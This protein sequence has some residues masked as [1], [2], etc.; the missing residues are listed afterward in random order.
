MSEY[1]LPLFVSNRYDHPRDTSRAF[2]TKYDNFFLSRLRFFLAPLSLAVTDLFQAQRPCAGQRQ[3]L[4][5]QFFSPPLL[6]LRDVYDFRKK[7]RSREFRHSEI[8]ARFQY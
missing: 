8:L 7:Y 3:T 6:L 5:Q 1:I 2:R 4:N